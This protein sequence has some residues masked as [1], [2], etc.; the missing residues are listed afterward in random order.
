M[1]LQQHSG[2]RVRAD[3]FGKIELAF[4]VLLARGQHRFVILTLSV[5][6]RFCFSAP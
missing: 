1:N 3:S 6:R 2:R 4:P 5:A